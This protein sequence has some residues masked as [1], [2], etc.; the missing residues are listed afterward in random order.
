MLRR[1]VQFS[2]YYVQLGSALSCHHSCHRT[3][4]LKNPASRSISSKVA[5]FPSLGKWDPSSS[6]PEGAR[7]TSISSVDHSG[8]EALI[9]EHKFGEVPHHHEVEVQQPEERDIA[10]ELPNDATGYDTLSQDEPI[11]SLQAPPDPPF[12]TL[13]IGDPTH[14]IGV[15]QAFME[16][17]YLSTNL[18]WFGVIVV[19]TMALRVSTFPFYVSQR[20]MGVKASH[21]S[22]HTNQF[23]IRMKLS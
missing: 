8:S 23:Y 15:L 20:K 13:G 10:A 3:L 11:A 18:S 12:D 14:P 22:P 4:I 1:Q 2:A 21:L 19:S 16:Q 17:L 5:L 6:P 7:D 9:A